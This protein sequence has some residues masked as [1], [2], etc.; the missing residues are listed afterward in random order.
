[1]TAYDAKTGEELYVQERVAGGRYYASPVAANGHIY[2]TS[3]EDG[4]VT[5]LKA[6]AEKPEV[7]APNPQLD[8]RVAATPAIADDTLYVRTASTCT[9]SPRRSEPEAARRPTSG[10]P[11][12]SFSNSAGAAA[13]PIPPGASEAPPAH[14]QAARPSAP[15][16]CEDR[17]RLRRFTSLSARPREYQPAAQVL[18]LRAWVA[19]AER[20]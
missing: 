8:E 11:S 19:G 4:V 13:A 20:D 5:V 7:V 2:F 12:L 17:S 10:R 15:R 1:M 3:L 6:G 18:K 9:R 16:R 14:P